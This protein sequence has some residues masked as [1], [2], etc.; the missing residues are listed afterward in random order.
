MDSEPR[1]TAFADDQRLASGDLR[2]VLSKTKRA[3]DSGR[4]QTILVFEDQ[5]GRQIEFDFEGTEDQVLERELPQKPK[6][7]PGRPKLGVVAKEVTLLPRHW[8]WLEQQPQGISGAL[9]RLVEEAS[10][11]EPDRQRARI[12]RDAASRVMWS[13][14]GNRPNFEEASRALFAGDRARFESLTRGWPQDVRDHLD[15]QLAPT[16]PSDSDGANAGP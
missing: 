5:S 9:R 12:A 6:S 11:R 16:W 4:H 7:G 2:E 15:Q 10:K 14:A 8:Q 13:M 3:I 1:Y